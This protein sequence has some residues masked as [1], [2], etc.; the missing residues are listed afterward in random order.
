[1]RRT[2]HSHQCVIMWH[3]LLITRGALWWLLVILSPG[4]YVPLSKSPV[5]FPSFSPYYAGLVIRDQ[6]RGLWISNDGAS[7]VNC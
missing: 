5:R 1:M 7:D 4:V 2:N 6:H 3:I